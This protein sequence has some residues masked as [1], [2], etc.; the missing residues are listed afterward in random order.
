[1]QATYGTLPPCHSPRKEIAYVALPTT[2]GHM[3]LQHLP[4]Y[5]SL[6]GETIWQIFE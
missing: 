4:V 5:G 6:R 2:G 3:L 1:V